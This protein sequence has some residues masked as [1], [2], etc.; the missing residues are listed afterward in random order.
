MNDSAVLTVARLVA[1]ATNNVIPETALI[2]GTI[3]AV[4]ERTRA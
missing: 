2:E 4:S 3:R 1:G